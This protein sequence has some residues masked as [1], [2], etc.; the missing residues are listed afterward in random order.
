M[1]K[2]GKCE[3]KR[4]R[5]DKK[6]KPEKAVAVEEVGMFSKP[7]LPPAVFQ[8]KIRSDTLLLAFLDPD[9]L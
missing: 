2:A 6:R 8:I 9:P 1:K 3:R 7:R 5:K 4:K